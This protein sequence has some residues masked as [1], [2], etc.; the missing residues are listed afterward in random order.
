[1]KSIFTIMATTSF[2]LFLAIGLWATTVIPGTSLVDMRIK[3]CVM[4]ATWGDG[5]CPAQEVSINLGSAK[6]FQWR[7]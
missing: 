7:P 2:L 1:M 5:H 4:G 6:L 3:V